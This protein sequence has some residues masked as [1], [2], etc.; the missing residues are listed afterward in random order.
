M[1]VCSCWWA[2][3]YQFMRSPALGEAVASDN[4]VYLDLEHFCSDSPWLVRKKPINFFGD[5]SFP[6]LV[7]QLSCLFLCIMQTPS[8]QM[9][10]GPFQSLIKLGGKIFFR[11]LYSSLVFAFHRCKQSFP[12]ALPTP[13][14][15]RKSVVAAVAF[16]WSRHSIQVKLWRFFPQHLPFPHRSRIQCQRGQGRA[17]AFCPWLLAHDCWQAFHWMTCTDFP[18]DNIPS[19]WWTRSPLVEGDEQ[20]RSVWLAACVGESGLRSS[21]RS[22]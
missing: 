19:P 13:S 14:Q 17:F 22:V 1:F 15:G 7:F 20:V 9:S 8:F 2:F 11:F 3:F 6:L 4:S 10:P 18:F 21:F 12:L 16:G 5:V